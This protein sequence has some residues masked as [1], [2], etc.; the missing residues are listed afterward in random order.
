MIRLFPLLAL[1]ISLPALA[2]MQR[3]V[4]AQGHVSYTD[5]DCPTAAR[6]AP[7]A[8][9]PARAAGAA[10]LDAPLE[11]LETGV[12]VILQMPGRFA[13][14]DDDTLAITTYADAHAKAPWMVRKIV[15][16]DVPGRRASVIVPRGF[17]DCVNADHQL[18]SLDVGDLESRFAIGSRAAPSVQ[19]F[20]VWDPAARKLSP[21][22]PGPRPVGTRPRA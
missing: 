3:C 20:A 12:P 2:D 16:Y 6:S 21:A 15:A 14:L 19:Q 9:A 8:A 18:V 11:V 10:P 5:Q 7:P 1:A 17:V 22:T 4:D 13:W